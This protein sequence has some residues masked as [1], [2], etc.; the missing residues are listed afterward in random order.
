M[1]FVQFVENLL[2]VMPYWHYK[3]D[4]PFKQLHKENQINMS[5]ETY[6]CLQMLHRDGAMTMSELAERLK[7]PKQQVTRLISIL[8][9]Y[10]FVRRLDDQKDR[11]VVRIEATQM[12][13]DYI[14]ENIYRNAAFLSGLEDKIGKEDAEEL[15]RAVESLLKILPK[16]D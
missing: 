8:F 1:D 4:K 5:M 3:I 10:D 9:Q 13:F 7:M 16:L 2:T 15:G 6:Y 11:R 12:A 14:R